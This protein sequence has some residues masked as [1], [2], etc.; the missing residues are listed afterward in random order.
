MRKAIEMRAPFSVHEAYIR[1][2]QHTDPMTREPVKDAAFDGL[3]AAIREAR[4]RVESM[5]KLPD[6]IMGDNKFSHKSNTERLRNELL[7]RAVATEMLLD[8]ALKGACTALTHLR[9][10]IF[11]ER[12]PHNRNR[13]C[14][15]KLDHAKRLGK[16]IEATQRAR[17]AVRS[18]ANGIIQEYC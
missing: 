16:A 7:R 3:E 15:A 13:P 2:F 8:D 12:T 14:S 18:F 6:A 10:G 1:K 5:A 11:D 17:R 4:A 9:S